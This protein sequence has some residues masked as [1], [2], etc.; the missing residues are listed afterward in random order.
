MSHCS[1]REEAIKA[2]G[3]SYVEWIE[4]NHWTT[5][6]DKAFVAPH[7]EERQFDDLPDVDLVLV[8]PGYKRLGGRHVKAKFLPGTNT[9]LILF[10]KRELEMYDYYFEKGLYLVSKDSCYES[11]NFHYNELPKYPIVTLSPIE[12]T[13]HLRACFNYV[14]GR[15]LQGLPV[16]Y[17]AYRHY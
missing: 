17:A 10:T 4:S 5:Y 15:V 9:C 3:K 14:I 11:K 12:D 13:D 16:Q 2:K 1:N 6:Y 7:A 8:R